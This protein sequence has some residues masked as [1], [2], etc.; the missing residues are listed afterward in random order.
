M[1]IGRADVD[2][3]VGLLDA[4]FASCGAVAAGGIK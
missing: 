2:Q 1:N 4:A 3:F